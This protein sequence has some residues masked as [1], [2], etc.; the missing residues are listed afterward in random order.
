[1][2]IV[3][4]APSHASDVARLHIAGQPGTF[5]TNLGPDILTLIY[6]T[7]PQSTSGFGFVM[8][9]KPSG[10]PHP[11]TRGQP[12]EP[13]TQRSDDR[14][15]SIDKTVDESI[16]LGFVAATTDTGRLFVDLGTRYF[17][18]F[19][20]KLL[21]RYLQQP[22]LLVQS[23]QTLFYPFVS[24]KH[25]PEPKDKVPPSN[26]LGPCAE[27]LAIMVEPHQRGLGIGSILLQQFITTC[28][29]RGVATVEVT[30]DAQNQGARRFYTHHGF[31]ERDSFML[32][33]R[34]MCRYMKTIAPMDKSS[35]TPSTNS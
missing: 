26:T 28:Q 2:E 20:P 9:A 10:K 24:Q 7:L 8:V 15:S 19:F 23:I 35:V 12:H 16:C 29:R 34:T 3:N 22:H 13:Q 31:T 14:Q 30:V 17:I 27:L 11:K 5:L 6:R 1:M 32:Y 33:G 21:K 25:Q 4:L 18:D